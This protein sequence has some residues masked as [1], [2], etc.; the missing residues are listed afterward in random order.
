M[1]RLKDSR[2]RGKAPVD[3]WPEIEVRATTQQS[4]FGGDHYWLTMD[5]GEPLVLRGPWHGGAPAGYVEVSFVD[6]DY[7]GN[8]ENR[9]NRK[10][11]WFRR[12]ATAGLYLTE[13]LFFRIIARFCAHA[14]LARVQH[15]Y[16]SRIEPYRSEWFMPKAAI[17]ELERSRA[18]RNEPAGKHWRV[19]WDGR[20]RY[21]GQLRIPSHG[22]L[23]EV[24]EADRVTLIHQAA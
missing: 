17:Y 9:W 20:G 10:R 14:S 11:P 24:P 5:D 19:Y 6:M 8:Q 2:Q 4:G 13:D 15:S 18:Q 23:D 21:C 22:Y 12:S 3:E 16:G 1:M 7:R